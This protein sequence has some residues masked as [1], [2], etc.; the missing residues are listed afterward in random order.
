[1]PIPDRPTFDS[2][3]PR[4]RVRL[5]DDGSP[6]LVTVADGQAMHSGCGAVAETRH[7]YL[8]GGDVER[9][10]EQGLPTRVLEVGFGSGLGWLL[11]ADLAVATGTTLS[12]TALEIDPPPAA[13]IRQLDLGRYVNDKT[14]VDEFCEW[15]DRVR[16]PTSDADQGEAELTFRFGPATLSLVIGDAL[17]WCEKWAGESPEATDE[18]CD[19]IYFDPYSP[20]AAPSLWRTEVFRTLRRRLSGSGRLVTY[21]VSRAVR[22]D[23]SAAGFQVTRVTGPP[24]GKR[25]VL[26]A[27]NQPEE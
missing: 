3:D 21:C 6:T 20:E 1:M 14:L 16:P 24:G 18:P 4:W 26:I 22:D 15:L 23:L 8:R 9:R 5:T 10:L 7:V 27:F 11:T 2:P 12:Y 17:R 13:V 19:S 25:E